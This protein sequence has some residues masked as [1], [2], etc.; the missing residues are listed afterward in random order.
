M[1]LMAPTE[2]GLLVQTQARRLAGSVK[3]RSKGTS[4]QMQTTCPDTGTG[5]PMHHALTVAAPYESLLLPLPR[6]TDITRHSAQHTN[7]GMRFLSGCKPVAPPPPSAFCSPPLHT[8]RPPPVP[9]RAHRG[10]LEQKVVSLRRHTAVPMCKT[11][12]ATAG[13]ASS[14]CACALVTAGLQP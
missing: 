10:Q 7:S 8:R 6:A 9:T 13:R 12:A 11:G 2:G 4:V 1:V 3:T 5:A 14:C